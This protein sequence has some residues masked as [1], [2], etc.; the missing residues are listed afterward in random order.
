MVLLWVFIVSFTVS[1]LVVFIRSW[2]ERKDYYERTTRRKKVWSSTKAKY[3]EYIERPLF[4]LSSLRYSY[5]SILLFSFYTALFIALFATFIAFLGTLIFG[6]LQV[7]LLVF[8]LEGLLSFFLIFLNALIP[9]VNLIDTTHGFGWGKMEE[10][11]M[12][13]IIFAM[14]QF[15]RSMIIITEVDHG[16]K[17][18]DAYFQQLDLFYTIPYYFGMMV[19]WEMLVGLTLGYLV[20]K[21]IIILQK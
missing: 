8:S 15:E 19:G 6:L 5:D 9:E 18:E 14:L 16:K 1:F 12:F 4:D 20:N 10:L 21:L 7:F 3:I 2:L 13:V 17:D 11:I